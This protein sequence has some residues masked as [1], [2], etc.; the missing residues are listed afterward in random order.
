MEST[1]FTIDTAVYQETPD[2]AMKVGRSATH[3]PL[4]LLVRVIGEICGY[5]SA[6]HQLPDHFGHRAD[7]RRPLDH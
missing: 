4:A 5:R 6:F 2:A 1:V 3:A 7:V